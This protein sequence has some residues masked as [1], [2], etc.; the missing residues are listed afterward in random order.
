MRTFLLLATLALGIHAAQ[1][2]YSVIIKGPFEDALY[3][4]AEDHDGQISAA[5]FTQ[6]YDTARYASATYYSAFDYLA[7]QNRTHGEQMR[8]I[9]LNEKGDTTLDT[10][11]E[12]PQ[13]N[14]AVSLIK[15]PA[16]GYVAGGYTQ[17]GELLVA[18]FNA[19]GHVYFT[20]TFGT[21]NNDRMHRLVALRDGGVLAV[22][23][24]VTSRDNRDPMFDQGLGGNDIFLTRFSK[25]GQ[26]LWSR[27]YGSQYDDTGIDAEE[28]FDGSIVVLSTSAIGADRSIHL[29]RLDENGE[30]IWSNTVASGGRH[31]AYDLLRRHNGRFIASLTQQDAAGKESIRLV[32][33]DLQQNMF[34][35]T[36]VTTDGSG[37]LYRLA[38]FN[39]GA[40]VGVG[41]ITDLQRGNTDAL[42]IGLTP[43]G[44]V[45]WKRSFGE[46]KRDLLRSVKVLRDGTIAAAGETT[47][48]G[49]EA[50]DMWIVRLNDDGSF[51]SRSGAARSL[52]DHL[53]DALSDDIAK[54][55]ITLSKD[56]RITLSHPVLLFKAGVYELTPVQKTFLELFSAKLL[57]ALQSYK[58]EI[59]ALRINGHTSSEWKGADFTDRYLNN[60]ELSIQRAFS[61]L[62]HIFRHK[63][64]AS[65]QQWLTE[66]LSNDGYSY[67]KM[68]KNPDED[69][70]ASRRVAFEIVLK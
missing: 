64:N 43:K 49:S 56:L 21:Q 35:D 33:F 48:P 25:E 9:R 30:K 62:S 3:D 13:F 66:V 1:S 54:G 26:K 17:N 14:R 32:S 42:V 28:A 5:G 69:R 19:A 50:T 45:Q 47:L 39:N 63:P 15:T 41:S 24:S 8:I 12:L 57:A 60:A 67:S 22:G 11:L 31:N 6:R 46:Q 53:A 18:K 20:R 51:T 23:S 65:Y 29:M 40:L 4:I 34:D 10:S 68:I 55:N 37:V 38:E 16:N 59:D 27:K 58:N 70:E 7:A 52:Y 36:N 2:S 44:N 61:V